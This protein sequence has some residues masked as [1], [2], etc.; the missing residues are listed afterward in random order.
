MSKEALLL[1]I[2]PI[3][4]IWSIIWSYIPKF[5]HPLF[6]QKFGPMIIPRQVSCLQFFQYLALSLEYEYLEPGLYYWKSDPDLQSSVLFLTRTVIGMSGAQCWSMCEEKTNRFIPSW[7]PAI[8][9]LS[10]LYE[11]QY[12]NIALELE[13]L[14]EKDEKPNFRD[15]IADKRRIEFVKELKK[16]VNMTDLPSILYPFQCLQEIIGFSLTYLD[17]DTF[18]FDEDDLHLENQ[19]DCIQDEST[20]LC[21][22]IF[23]SL[24]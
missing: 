15:L 17:H 1:E 12:Y 21:F 18:P 2:L 3:R 22:I 4:D 16:Y 10:L 20:P 13:L 7:S 24:Y 8:I 5:I 11:Q 23:L 14:E 19:Y 6:I 9:P